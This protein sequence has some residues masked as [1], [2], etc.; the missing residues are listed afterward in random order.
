MSRSCAAA[1]SDCDCRPDPSA[2]AG[3][4]PVTNSPLCQG[5]N[6]AY[7]TTQVKAKAYP[8]IRELQ[9]LKGIGDQAIVASIC[10]AN[11]ADQNATDYGYR[12]AIAALID[13]LRNALRG[14]CLPRQLEIDADTGQAPCVIVEAFNPANN[15]TCDGVCNDPSYAGRSEATGDVITDEIAKA[16][17]C[18]CLIQQLAGAEQTSCRNQV[19]APASIS[20]GW[21]YVDPGQSAGDCSLVTACSPSD[22]RLIKFV[23]TPS[24]P[25]PGATAYIMCQER[26]FPA[27][28]GD[29]P[30]D[31]CAGK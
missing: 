28:G 18:H 13:R 14:R 21:C 16:G 26:S 10:P 9:V 29:Q 23:N 3:S 2:P 11:T 17:S 4:A 30:M 1:A 20:G 31:P 27:N 5:A 6:N 25:R 12:P 19:T 22:R 7:S 8:G 15:G 24:E